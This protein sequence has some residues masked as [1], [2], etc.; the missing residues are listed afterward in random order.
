MSG[1]QTIAVLTTFWGVAMAAS[2]AL[3]IRRIRR[4]GSSRGV[5]AVQILVLLVGF[6]LWLLYGVGEGSVPLIVTNVVALIVNGAWLR[7]TLRHRPRDQ[8]AAAAS[9][10]P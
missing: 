2:P 8:A 5:S 10:S 9:Q 7:S 1:A 6:A 4:E 3:Q